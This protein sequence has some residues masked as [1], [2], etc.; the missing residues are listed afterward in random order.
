MMTP[1]QAYE[2]LE[3]T[4]RYQL[5]HEAEALGREWWTATQAARAWGV[6]PKTARRLFELSGEATTVI[7]RNVRTDRVR[8]LRCVRAGTPKPASRKGNPY[9]ADPDWQRANVRKRWDGHIT[10][11]E[12]RNLKDEMELEAF[13]DL[14]EQVREFVPD[15]EEQSEPWV[16]YPMRPPDPDPPP[17]HFLQ[18]WERDLYERRQQRQ[19]R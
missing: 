5:P 11:A 1:L 12:L 19:R 13:E 8:V 3:D 2:M 18:K 16:P 15:P 9:F 17:P 14:R 4:P 10:A 6:S 7:V